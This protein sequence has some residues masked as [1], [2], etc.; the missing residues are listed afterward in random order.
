MFYDLAAH[1][2]VKKNQRILQ[3]KETEKVLTET[4]YSVFISCKNVWFL[5]QDLNHKII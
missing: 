1:G 2:T 4:Q 3:I 5:D